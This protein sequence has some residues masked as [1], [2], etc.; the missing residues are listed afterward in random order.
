MQNLTSSLSCSRAPKFRGDLSSVGY[1]VL[2]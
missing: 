2:W 1:N